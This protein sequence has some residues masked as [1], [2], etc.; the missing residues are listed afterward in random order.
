MVEVIVVEVEVVVVIVEEAAVVVE[1]VLVVLIVVEWQIS[2]SLIQFLIAL[3]HSILM[4]IDA[5][6]I[7]TS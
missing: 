5:S 3:D 2:I 4:I 7:M 1:V 6:I